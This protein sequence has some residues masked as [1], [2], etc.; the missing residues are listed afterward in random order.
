MI[1]KKT[2]CSVVF[3]LVVFSSVIHASQSQSEIYFGSVAMDTP[4]V[5]HERLKP[6]TNYLSKTLNRTVKLKLAPNMPSA[7]DDL[8]KATVDLAYLTPVAYLR[9]HSKGNSRIV[10]KTVTNK[11]SSFQ[12]M[13]VVAED[14]PIKKVEDLFGKKFAFGDKAA[15]LQRAAVVGAGVPLEKL[16]SYDFLGHYDNIV[17][18]V[19]RGHYDAGILKDTMAFKWKGK[20]IR[21]LHSSPQLP[22]YNIAVSKN[23]DDELFNKIRK[24]FLDLDVKNPEHKA[25]IKA[26]DKK[27]DG[28]APTNDQEYDVVRKLISPFDKK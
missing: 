2:L 1:P 28:F 15:F 4:A 3:I 22:P 5:M 8:S 20:G 25:V 26:L 21:I 14:S 13:I 16:G 9:S 27:Y 12:L 19:M 17:R 6:L 24:A 23:I 18:A 10:A 7:I 11:K